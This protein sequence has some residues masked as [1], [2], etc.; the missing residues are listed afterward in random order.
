M[1][2]SLRQRQSMTPANGKAEQRQA[3]TQIDL[4]ARKLRQP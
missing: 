2:R 4:P 1:R 3:A